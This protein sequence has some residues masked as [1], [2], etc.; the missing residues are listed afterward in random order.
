MP[1][2]Q[3]AVDD[4]SSSDDRN[5]QVAADRHGPLRHPMIGTILAVAWILRDIV[6]PNVRFAGEVGPKICIARDCGN[7]ENASFGAPASDQQGRVAALVDDVV[8]KRPELGLGQP[9][10]GFVTA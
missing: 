6:E 1:E 7:L 3:P 8:E 5:G 9:G 10:R 2:E 4:A